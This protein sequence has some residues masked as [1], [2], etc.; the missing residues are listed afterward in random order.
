MVEALELVGLELGEEIFGW[1]VGGGEIE[2]EGV[3]IVTLEKE[4]TTAFVALVP[5]MD[6]LDG[7]V[8]HVEGD[9]VDEL[10]VGVCFGEF[11]FEEVE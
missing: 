2:G 8:V 6:I 9:M 5:G 10:P 4:G 7:E 1:F 3:V 11:V